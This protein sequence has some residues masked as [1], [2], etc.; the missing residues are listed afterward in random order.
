MA[1]AVVKKFRDKN[2][3]VERKIDRLHADSEAIQVT[4]MRKINPGWVLGTT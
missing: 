2:S 1:I 3:L 4:S